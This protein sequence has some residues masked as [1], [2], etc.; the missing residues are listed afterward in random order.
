M[1][2]CKHTVLV[3]PLCPL[4]EPGGGGALRA[5]FNLACQARSHQEGLRKDFKFSSLLN[6]EVGKG[7]SKA[8]F[9]NKF[10]RERGFLCQA[11]RAGLGQ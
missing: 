8:Q 1:A 2:V 4:I 6:S 9:Q 7:T 11:R 10:Y 5:T 3:T